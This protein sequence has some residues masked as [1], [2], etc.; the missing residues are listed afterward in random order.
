MDKYPAS[1][2]SPK[3]Q[4]AEK[5]GIILEGSLGFE[6]GILNWNNYWTQIVRIND[7][8]SKA[9]RIIFRVTRDKKTTL[10]G[11]TGDLPED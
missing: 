3:N 4:Q 7:K 1:A 9:Q 8:K 5:P 10:K 2:S 11:A 6:N